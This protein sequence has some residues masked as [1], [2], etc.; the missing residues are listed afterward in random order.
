MTES[1]QIRKSL[2]ELMK[3]GEEIYA[4]VC[5]VLSIDTAAKTIDVKPVDDTAEIFNVPLQADTQGD[6]LV[7]FPAAGSKVLVV[8]TSKHTAVMCNA[9]EVDGMAYKDTKGVELI[10]KDGKITVKNSAYGIAQAFN[11]LIDAIGKL[12]VTTG[13]GPSG[14]PVNKSEFDAIKQNLGNLLV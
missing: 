4:K 5:E 2:S 8:F 3:T 9:G 6:G 14:I 1:G 10:I 12:T 11:D 13:V 7:V